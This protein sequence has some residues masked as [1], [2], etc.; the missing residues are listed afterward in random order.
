LSIISPLFFVL[1]FYISLLIIWIHCY[2]YHLINNN[3]NNIDNRM[4]SESLHIKIWQRAFNTIAIIFSTF[5]RLWYD[6][7]I[8]GIDNLPANGPALLV[9]YHGTWPC[10]IYF[11]IAE[12]YLCKK[13]IMF[14]IVERIIYLLPGWPILLRAL[15][16]VPGSVNDCVQM[17]NNGSMVALSPGGLREAMFS[18]HHHYEIIHSGRLGF[19]RVAKQANV[20]IIPIFTRNIRESFRQVP[21]MKNFV[22]FI[23]DRYRIPLFLTYGGFPV[24]LTTIIGEPIRFQSD[25]TVEQIAE[26]VINFFTHYL[27]T[28]YSYYYC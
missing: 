5:G 22:K 27:T 13:R 15:R 12:L 18:D 1:L 21:I 10:D 6:Y 2:R 11:L 4:R 19:A 16:L 26:M 20:P 8:I 3:D 28:I 17:L 23:Y 25:A 14:T 7:E 24:K 9:F